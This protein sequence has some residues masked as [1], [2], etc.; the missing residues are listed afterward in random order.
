MPRAHL[1]SRADHPF[2]V[3]PPRAR[4]LPRLPILALLIAALALVSSSAALF[5][6]TTAS[7]PYPYPDFE[8]GDTAVLNITTSPVQANQPVYRFRQKNGLNDGAQPTYVGTTD[9]N[10]KLT[11]TYTLQVTDVGGYTG[12]KFAVGSPTAPVSN[13]LAYEVHANSRPEAIRYAP[14]PDYQVGDLA[15]LEVRTQPAQ[16]NQ[17]VYRYRYKNGSSDGAQPTLIGWTDSSGTLVVEGTL[18]TNEIGEYVGERYAVGTP[19]SPRSYSKVYSVHAAAPPSATRTAPYPDYRVGDTARLEISTSPA[20]GYQKV[21]RYRYRDGQPDGS[22]PQYIGTTNSSGSLVNTYT[23]QASDIGTYSQESFTVGTPD[24]PSSTALGYTVRDASDPLTLDSI[25]PALV[26]S[27]TTTVVELRGTGLAGASVSIAG[28]GTL[29]LVA[30]AGGAADGT[31]LE[32]AIDATYPAEDVVGFYDL[33]VSQGAETVT[34]RL[35][36]YPAGGPFVDAY[37]PSK[38]ERG[39]TYMLMILGENLEGASISS[40]DL[41]RASVFAMGSSDQHLHA[42]LQVRSFATL[43]PLDLTLRGADGSGRTVQVEIVGPGQSASLGKTDHALSDPAASSSPSSGS[44]SAS[45]PL[46]TAGELTKSLGAPELFVQDFA[47]VSPRFGGGLGSVEPHGDCQFTTSVSGF[48]QYSRV[49]ISDDL[50]E[51]REVLQLL[52][53]E[54]RALSVS[55]VSAYIH[56]IARFYWN[57]DEVNG[58]SELY[59][60][61]N[62]GFDILGLYS[63]EF[64]VRPY[65]GRVILVRSINSVLDDFGFWDASDDCANISRQAPLPGSEI[66]DVQQTGCCAGRVPVSFSGTIFSGSPIAEATVFAENL[67][68]AET[69]PD[70]ESCPCPAETPTGGGAGSEP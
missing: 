13:T 56:A 63:L 22:Q 39:R 50:G 32:V 49:V 21:Y 70:P 28:D 8:V 61:I 3:D 33:T 34:G 11:N 17:K 44:G 53:G 4:L 1:P 60:E 6:G 20:Q 19:D 18:T 29:P 25:V 55:T 35:E 9:A 41:D 54:T 67:L 52:V 38:P 14:Y 16:P 69:L 15:R 10:G 48:S 12:E 43:G 64:T 47:M 42:M 66:L 59:W 36:V 68:A 45:S 31:T 23:L 62:L 30:V 57:C 7:R 46:R 37:S 5:A 58:D 40:T 51:I 26:P 27:G 2:R 65:D 24:G